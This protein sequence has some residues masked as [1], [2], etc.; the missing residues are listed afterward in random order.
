[1]SKTDPAHRIVESTKEVHVPMPAAAV[2]S[3]LA[4]PDAIAQW[5]PWTG[6]VTERD[7][8]IESTTRTEAPGGQTVD[9]P[10]ERRRQ[11]IERYSEK[12]RQG[13]RISYPDAED[14]NARTITFAAQPAGSGTRL[15][16]TV[17]WAVKAVR[18]RGFAGAL[19]LRIAKAV[20]AAQ[21]RVIFEQV[22]EALR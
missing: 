7:G 5:E 11:V 21:S 13:W 12:G 18:S 20:Y 17:S 9:V 8:L 16:I 10:E 4:R 6:E 22:K 15:R 2:R 19:S 14:P 1:M 3:L